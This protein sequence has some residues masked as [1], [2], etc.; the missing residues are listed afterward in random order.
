MK[1]E[2]KKSAKKGGGMFENLFNQN[3]ETD[4]IDEFTEKRRIDL[5]EEE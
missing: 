1:T 3:L 4:V 5:L 2:K